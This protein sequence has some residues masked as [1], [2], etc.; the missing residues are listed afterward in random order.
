M[1]LFALSDPHLS[2]VQPKPMG[3][4]GPDWD[5]HDEKIVEGWEAEVSSED[6]VLVPGDISWAMY[7][8]DA[9]PDLDFLAA[10]PG[11]SVILRGNH[12]YWWNSLS[13]VR[14]ALPPN[15]SALQNDAMRSHEYLIAG[16]RLWVSPGAQHF[17]AEDEKIYQRELGRLELSLQAAEKIRKPD[18][19]FVV[20]IH[21][22]PFNERREANEVSELLEKHH[23]DVLL[24][25]H[26]HGRSMRN[27]F[28]GEW[29][30]CMIHLVSGDHI[31]FRPRLIADEEW[32]Y[33]PQ[34][35]PW[36]KKTH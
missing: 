6:L 16:T 23:V 7:L 4:F 2:H 10:L 22:P 26:L 36:K 30:G 5:R 25:G 32:L 24:Y 13:K 9:K 18:D 29:N 19:T 12:D 17:G 27:A 11:Q 28:E 35:L 33:D 8:E 31:G 1:K 21:Y 15:M 20:M 14:S 34:G 3:V